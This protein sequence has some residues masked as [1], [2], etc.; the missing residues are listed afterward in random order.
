MLHSINNSNKV[1]NQPA[2]TTT[3]TRN[4]TTNTAPPRCHYGAHNHRHNRICIHNTS[5]CPDKWNHFQ[6]HHATQFNAH[7]FPITGHHTFG[8]HNKQTSIGTPPRDRWR[9]IKA[10]DVLI[11]Q[12]IEHQPGPYDTNHQNNT[13]NN[14]AELQQGKGTPTHLNTYNRHEEHVDNQL[15][16]Y[17]FLKT[18]L[19]ITTSQHLRLIAS[20]IDETLKLN[21]TYH[22]NSSHAA[23]HDG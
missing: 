13:T 14:F 22:N 20:A 18:P 6:Y 19:Q 17:D 9:Y 21:S 12:G 7:N 11:E 3:T 1:Q 5:C 10:L 4:T 15:N 23:Q 8:E 2:D 16:D